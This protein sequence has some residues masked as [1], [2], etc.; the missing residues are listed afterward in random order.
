M[1]TREQLLTEPQQQTPSRR[2]SE[3]RRGLKELLSAW[4]Q[5]PLGAILK[6]ETQH[7]PFSRG[8][9][10]RGQ[11]CKVCSWLPR[12]SPLTAPHADL[13]CSKAW[14]ASVYPGRAERP[15]RQ[16]LVPGDTVAS[17]VSGHLSEK[18]PLGILDPRR[19]ALLHPQHLSP[20]FI[21]FIR[22]L[23]YPHHLQSRAESERRKSSGEGGLSCSRRAGPAAQT[24]A[25]SL[26]SQ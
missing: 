18:P 12:G 13:P 4:A 25:N 20:A 23:Y 14:Q 9:Q 22:Y 8:T 3:P 15:K 7:I 16:L 17:G 5:P 2:V 10:S 1:R 6:R 11:L 21:P 26:C 19:P 24:H